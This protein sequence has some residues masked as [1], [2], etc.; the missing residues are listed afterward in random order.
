MEE[1]WVLPVQSPRRMLLVL[2]VLDLVV[3]YSIVD[4]RIAK[5][6]DELHDI[7]YL[8]QENSLKQKVNLHLF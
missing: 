4:N 7:V 5:S 1:I 6:V 2:V 8:I 3:S